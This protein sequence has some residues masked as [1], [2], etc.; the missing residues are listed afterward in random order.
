MINST[1]FNI[2]S[3]NFYNQISPFYSSINTNFQN[4]QKF[5]TD[6]GKDLYKTVFINFKLVWKYLLNV[7]VI[8]LS[9]TNVYSFAF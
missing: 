6:I 1:V 9:N 7:R 3:L 4:K 8:I 5:E 2:R